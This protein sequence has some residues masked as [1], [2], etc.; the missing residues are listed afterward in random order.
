MTDQTKSSPRSDVS[1]LPTEGATALGW[2]LSGAVACAY[3]SFLIAGALV[4]QSLARPA[5]GSIPWSFLLSAGLLVGV[6]ATM[7]LYVLIVNAREVASDRNA[8]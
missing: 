5:I 1:D 6:V 4:P 2:W 8:K 3:F 7:G